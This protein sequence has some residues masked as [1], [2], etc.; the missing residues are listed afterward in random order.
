MKV[1][2]LF[3]NGEH[4]TELGKKKIMEIKSTMNNKRT[5]FY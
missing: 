3:S 1:V 2:D 5:V 4:K